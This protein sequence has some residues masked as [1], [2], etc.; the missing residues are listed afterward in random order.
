MM[1]SDNVTESRS[2]TGVARRQLASVF[3]GKD[4]FGRFAYLVA[5]QAVT[6]VLGFVFWGFATRFM[7]ATQVGLATSAVFVATLLGT[8][9]ILGAGSILV[10]QLQR[11]SREEQRALIRACVTVGA[12]IT[13]LLA[14]V[15]WGASPVLGESFRRVGSN[16]VTGFLFIA[17]TTIQTAA[18]L[19][20]AAAIGL[21][22]GRAQLGRNLVAALLK[23][24][25]LPAALLLGLRNSTGLLAGWDLSML[26]SLLMVPRLLGFR[27]S[28]RVPVR[29]EYRIWAMVRG[30]GAVALRHH[31]INVAITSVS[32]VLPVVAALVTLPRELAYFSIAQ[33]IA[34]CALALPYLLMT[35]L[36]AEVPQGAEQLRHAV[37]RTFPFGI[38]CSGLA[39]LVLEAGANVLLSVFG[40]QYAAHGAVLL[41]F[42]LIACIPYVVKDHFVVVRRAQNRLGEAARV[43]A[44][45]TLAEIGAGVAGGVVAGLPGLCLGWSLCTVVEGAYFLPRVLAILREPAVEEDQ[46]RSAVMPEQLVGA[47]TL[48]D[49]API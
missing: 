6:V 35:S 43:A 36:F 47:P 25:L 16:P 49:A 19:F 3:A 23:L 38:V 46:S 41:R 31:L 11:T 40:H 33:L 27:H 45:C 1:T 15:A 13:T 18:I 12:L 34:S 39:V 32:Y 29:A 22:R 14:L 21:H 7:P 5:T 44:L 9:G 26:L 28:D 37:R 2:F 10:L 17:G 8:L 4:L 20:D 42:L 24:A 30:R 48:G